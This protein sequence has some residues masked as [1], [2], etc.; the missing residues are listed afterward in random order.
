MQNQTEQSPSPRG[1]VTRLTAA[2]TILEA[3]L[4]RTR[5]LHPKGRRRFASQPKTLTSVPP[6]A[7]EA[8]SK[9]MGASRPR[10]PK[11]RGDSRPGRVGPL[12]GQCRALP[13]GPERCWPPATM[14]L[15]TQSSTRIL[16]IIRFGDPGA[17]GQIVI[18]DCLK[19]LASLL[20]LTATCPFW[21]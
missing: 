8:V 20:A 12:L 15:E 7:V 16:S 18:G 19:V 17:R 11:A 3:T 13:S 10:W 14:V 2:T 4:P 21:P 5:Q 1:S 6:N 9:A